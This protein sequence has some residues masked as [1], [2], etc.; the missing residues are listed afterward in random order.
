MKSQKKPLKQFS[1][2]RSRSAY[3]VLSWNPYAA[4]SIYHQLQTA[5]ANASAFASGLW[6]ASN[7]AVRTLRSAWRTPA[8]T[9]SLTFN[10]YFFN[11]LLGPEYWATPASR[12][13]PSSTFD[14]LLVNAFQNP[15][16]LLACSSPSLLNVLYTKMYD[17]ARERERALI[18]SPVALPCWRRMND[19]INSA[20][21]SRVEQPLP[22]ISRFCRQQELDT[23]ALCKSWAYHLPAHLW[24]LFE[25]IKASKCAPTALCTMPYPSETLCTRN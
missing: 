13:P 25:L 2:A 24:N 7:H 3:L 10:R 9:L 4:E 20:K 19:S 8:H 18:S 21:A 16:M 14:R 11:N 5:P 1:C 6:K 12:C 22:Y 23:Q 17:S 15:L